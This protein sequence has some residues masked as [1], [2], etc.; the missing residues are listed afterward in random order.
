MGYASSLFNMMRNT[1]A[2]IGISFLTAIV[3]RH[4]QLHQSVLAEHFS[5]FDAWRLTEQASR[6]PGAPVIGLLQPA[7]REGLAMIYGII[8]SQA[9]VLAFNDVYR[10]LAGWL[11]LMIPFYIVLRK[12]PMSVGPASGH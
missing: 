7:H 12:A 5:I 6:M 1:G 8:Q 4:Q 3:V 10:M 11:L 9:A 2:A